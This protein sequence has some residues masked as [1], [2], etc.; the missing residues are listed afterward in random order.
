ML[1]VT[2]RSSTAPALC[3]LRDAQECPRGLFGKGASR[4]RRL[5]TTG[6]SFLLHYISKIPP[7]PESRIELL[8]SLLKAL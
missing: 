7:S 2:C 5:R 1:P 4:D 6:Q 8:T 3:L